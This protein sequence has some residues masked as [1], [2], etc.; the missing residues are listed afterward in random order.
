MA[1]RRRLLTEHNAE[2]A[3]GLGQLK[4]RIW[5]VGVMGEGSRKENLLRLLEA[6][7]QSLVAEGYACDSGL[8]AAEKVFSEG[9]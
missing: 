8:T 3:G 4:G 9:N 1:V 6:I 5:R 2:I 7:H